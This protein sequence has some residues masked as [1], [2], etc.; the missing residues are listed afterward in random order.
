MARWRRP[1]EFLL[2]GTRELVIEALVVVGLA[3]FAL[4]VALIILWLG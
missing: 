1:F 4:F 3:V 2:S